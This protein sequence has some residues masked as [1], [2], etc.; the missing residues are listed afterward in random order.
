M[1]IKILRGAVLSALLVGLCAVP[2]LAQERV[3]QGTVTDGATGEPLP[4][5]NVAVQGAQGGTTTGSDGTYQIEVPGADAVLEFSFV[6]YRTR[7]VRVRNRETINVT[8]RERVGQLDEVVVT[9]YGAQQREEISGAISSVDVPAANVG[10]VSS[11]QDLIQGRVAGV[12]IVS[13]SG[14][15]GS[16]QR[17]RIRGRKSLSASADPLYVID[18][19][20]IGNTNVTPSGANG[21]TNS[22]NPLSFINPRDIE[23]IQVLK[24]PAATAIYG[25]QGSNG[26]LVI[27]TKGGT[28][29]RLQV[30]YSGQTSM[31]SPANELNLLTPD[32][33]RAAREEFADADL[34]G[35]G[36]NTDWQ[37]EVMRSTLSHEHNLSFSGSTGQTSY[38]GSASYFDQEGL[39]RS[40]GL[41]RITGRINASHTALDD[42]LR[43][44]LRLFRSY[45]ERNHSFRQE[46]GGG[47]GG[48]VIKDMLTFPPNRPVQQDGEFFEYAEQNRNPVAMLEQISDVSNQ[49]RTLGNLDLQFDLLDNLTVEGTFSA[50]LSEG[51][52]RTYVPIAS[53]VGRDVGGIGRQA[54][55]EFQS[56]VT[57]SLV[58]Y[59]R[60][61]L[62]LFGLE[63]SVR[64]LGGFEFER[65]TFQTI[66]VETQ[67]FVT[68]AVPGFNNL[69]GGSNVQT[70]S[71]GKEQVDQ[72]SFFGQ[73]NYN[74]QDKYLVTA[75]LRRDGSS[76]FGERDKFALF[77]SASLGWN[78]AQEPFLDVQGLS[79]LKVRVSGGVSG[80]QG[81]P[82]LQTLPVLTAS[83]GNAGVFGAD[84]EVIGVAQT[85]T[86]SPGLKWEE[87]TEF[88]VGVDFTAGR[89]S[90]TVDYYRSQTEDLLLNV[91]VVQP[92]PSNFVLDNVGAVSNTGV[93]ASLEALVLDRQDVNLTV[94]AN[95]SSNRNEVDDLGG[96]G[97]IDH[98]TVGGRGQS[99]VTSQRLEP[100]HPIGSFYGPVFVRVNDNGEEVYRTADGGTTT[101]PG[102]AADTHL[103]NPIPD[104][105]YSLNLDFRYRNFDFSAFFRGEQGREL[106]NNTGLVYTSKSRLA[107]GINMLEPALDDGTTTNHTATYSSR[108]VQDAS[109]FRL[110]KLSVGYNLSN[111]FGNALYD[112]RR[113]RIFASADNLFVIT[114]YSGYDPELNT[115]TSGE[116][117]GFRN[118]A[119]PARGIDWTSYPR[120]RTFTLGIELGF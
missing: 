13:N 36:V 53:A 50:D 19:V 74:Y 6:G 106:F 44:N 78:V 28:A 33:F 8:L 96:R 49:N 79:Q 3:V 71:S 29:G 119:T 102:V 59:D 37:D 95:A 84:N 65:E 38:R 94:T 112:F 75:S 42:R 90:G 41:E 115:N 97:T 45:L 114:P 82:P 105:A 20:P 118:L 61:A 22:A 26:V 11:P 56:F 70:P 2:A 89:F 62:S 4:G 48:S 32:E 92:A 83:R 60:D 76:V 98:G 43:L 81:V 9:G 103:G 101:D 39:L 14:A 55:R 51:Q 58:T 67:D 15:P 72:V 30:D 16:G 23:S 12:S 113:A 64:L 110:D 120:P 85:R 77:P 73:F 117:L 1:L 99:G 25:S 86:A 52:R 91:R 10:Q 40:T 109:F 107:Q 17:V 88:N 116:G 21:A 66:G 47:T 24:G 54:E 46:T 111:A 68:D 104:V 27:E 80:N 108:W 87:T 57:Q 63:H 18:G 93:E 7:R 100:G 31:G 69:G 35:T 5:A 34:P